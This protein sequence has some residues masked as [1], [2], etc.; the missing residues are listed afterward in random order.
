MILMRPCSLKDL[1]LFAFPQFTGHVMESSDLLI[2]REIYLLVIENM[3]INAAL[4]RIFEA[5]FHKI[6]HQ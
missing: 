1:K 2:F 4:T 5:I 3:I 6:V